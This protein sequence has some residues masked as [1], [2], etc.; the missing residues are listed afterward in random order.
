V[1]S[2]RQLSESFDWV[3]W[4]RDVA[5]R[6]EGL[7]S[8]QAA[9]ETLENGHKAVDSDPVA[10]HLESAER[11]WAG[12]LWRALCLAPDLE[13]LEALLDGESVPLTRLDPY[14]SKRF[15]LKAA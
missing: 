2:R 3:S 11:E 1:A 8:S 9:L 13:T 6:T 12:E 14:W 4:A 15:G 5:V 10:Q 7:R